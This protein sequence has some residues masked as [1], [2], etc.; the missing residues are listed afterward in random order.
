MLILSDESSDV[1]I[2]P[3]VDLRNLTRIHQDLQPIRRL[4]QEVV[5]MGG[6]GG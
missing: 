1:R 4:M 2:P 3:I 6:A 5:R